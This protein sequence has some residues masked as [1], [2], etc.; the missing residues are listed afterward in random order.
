MARDDLRTSGFRLPLEPNSRHVLAVCKASRTCV[1]TYSV[2]NGIVIRQQ[3]TFSGR[4]VR[5][6]VPSN[7][8]VR[9]GRFDPWPT[10]GYN[11]QS[12]AGIT[13]DSGDIYLAFTTRLSDGID[14]F[15]ASPGGYDLDT[16][17]AI[18]NSIVDYVVPGYG[19]GFQGE[20]FNHI[21]RS[22]CSE[23]YL[24]SDF[25]DWRMSH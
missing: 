4:T 19:Q 6:V 25:N 16:F 22:I 23:K 20:G 24:N 18:S 14:Y 17:N 15:Y 2:H 13:G 3:A 9:G 21:M 1:H 8:P 11:F 7:T 12:I 10:H 5:V